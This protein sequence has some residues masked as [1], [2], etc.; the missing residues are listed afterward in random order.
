[1]FLGIYAIHPL[2]RWLEDNLSHFLNLKRWFSVLVLRG[3]CPACCRCFSAPKNTWFKWS[4]RHHSLL[5]PDNDP[6]SFDPWQNIVFLCASYLCAWVPWSCLPELLIWPCACILDFG[7]LPAPDWLLLLD[8]TLVLTIAFLPFLYAV[9][10]C[11]VIKV[12]AM[13]LL[14]LS[15][16]Q[17]YYP[18]HS[19]YP[20]C[21]SR[22]YL[23]LV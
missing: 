15:Y 1:M 22:A 21:T 4:D 17:L 20:A 7:F 23:G 12:T 10:H 14:C 16:L 13:H 19:C 6:T 5:K 3:C 8:C 2:Y 9:V 18:L 11:F